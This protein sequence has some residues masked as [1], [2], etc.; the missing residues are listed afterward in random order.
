MK[1]IP[2][3]SRFL[4]AISFSQGNLINFSAIGRDCGVDRKTIQAYVAILEDLLVAFR[5][6][7]FNKKAKRELV[8]HE[9]FY[10]FDA[11]VYRTIRPAVPLDQPQEIDGA[12]LETLII[13]QVRAWASYRDQGDQ[14]FFWRSR[15]GTEV[16]LVVYGK[17]GIWAI[18]IKN[19]GKVRP[20]DL[21]GLKEFGR[22]YPMAE[23]IL[24]YRGKHRE[25]IS[26]ITCMPIT[27]FLAQLHPGGS[28][29]LIS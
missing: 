28:D 21:T 23:R 25:V 16:D 15:G 5:L 2:T 13:Q 10:Y 6:P 26:G 8:S 7:V 20:E 9:K 12:A 4:E 29:P 27:E 14:L 24:L 18:E 11:G 3:F 22:D 17:G 1:S 19:S